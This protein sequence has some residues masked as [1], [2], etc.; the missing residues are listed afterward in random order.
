MMERPELVCRM[1]VAA[2]RAEPSHRS[3]LI[4]QLLFGERVELLEKRNGWFLV[5]S[6]IDA[7]R[8]WV[9]ILEV[10]PFQSLSQNCKQVVC[11]E[12]IIPIA[13][14]DTGERQWLT[15][16]A[17]TERDEHGRLRVGDK[18]YRY[19]GDVRELCINKDSNIILQNA[20]RWL[21]APYLWGGRTPLGVDC[22]GFV[23]LVFRASGILLP[24]D[25]WQ[26]AEF[27][28]DIPF[29]SEALAGD[30]AFF[31]NIDGKIIHVGLL[32]GEGHIVHAS[33]KVRI[34]AFDHQGIFNRETMR[35]THKL[36]M[37]RR[38]L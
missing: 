17:M 28:V 21:N 27:G 11:H 30:L 22:S 34:D 1:P 12:L 29:A 14:E 5:K 33:G 31:E 3:E 23:Q 4:N 7:Y 16:G 19:M 32:N 25:A 9:D 24:R 26:Q 37:I 10:E 20:L 35:Y 6:L 36:K 13:D 8:G 2:M 15:F 38:I 18:F